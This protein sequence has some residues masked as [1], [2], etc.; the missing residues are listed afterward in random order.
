M[1]I[2]RI[3][4]GMSAA[5]MAASM[6]NVP[7]FADEGSFGT[8]SNSGSLVVSDQNGSTASD[9][10]TGSED[11]VYTF[12]WDQDF[13]EVP[14]DWYSDGYISNK[15]FDLIPKGHGAKFAVD[16]ELRL[17][18]DY[19]IMALSC[20]NGWS[21]LYDEL[22]SYRYDEAV[23]DGDEELAAALKP[24]LWKATS[25]SGIELKSSLSEEEIEKRIRTG[26]APVLQNDGFFVLYSSGTMEFEIS[27]DAVEYIRTNLTE[28][29]NFGGTLF[30]CYGVDITHIHVED[31]ADH[32]HNYEKKLIKDGHEEQYT[33]SICGDSYTKVIGHDYAETEMI[34]EP[35]CTEEGIVKYICS[36]GDSYTKAVSKKGHV[37]KEEKAA[38]DTITYV[39][40]NCDYVYTPAE[41]C[42]CD[43]ET[44]PN[45]DSEKDQCGCGCKDE[46]GFTAFEMWSDPQWSPSANWSSADTEDGHG[47]D[48]LINKDGTYTVSF[49]PTY[50]DATNDKVMYEKPSADSEPYVWKGGDNIWLVDI[51]GLADAVGANT[52]DVIN[53][54]GDKL[55][56]SEKHQL[57]KEAGIKITN[58]KLYVDGDL[59]YTIPDDKLLYGDLEENGN[60][61]IEIYNQFTQGTESRSSDYD[62]PELYNKLSGLTA[63]QVAVTFDIAGVPEAPYKRCVCHD[64]D[65]HTHVF[66]P[67]TYREPTCYRLGEQHYVC[68]ICGLGY[69]EYIETV[70]HTYKLADIITEPT[71]VRQ[72][73]GVYRCTVCGDEYMDKIDPVGH[74]YTT[75]VFEPSNTTRGYTEYTCENCGDTFKDDYVPAL[76]SHEYIGKITKMPTCTEEGV[77]TYTCDDGDDSYTEAIPALGH[78]YIDRV[79][80]ATCTEKGY[81]EHVCLT[82]GDK[83]TSD[84]TAAKGHSY[85]LKS[86]KAA[87][88][89][90][91]GSKTYVCES[92]GDSYV[93]ITPVRGHSYS[94]EV[95][96]PT[97][98]ERGYTLHTCS[99]CGDSYKDNFTARLERTSIHNAVISIANKKYVYS[100]KKIAPSFTVKLNGKLLVSG[101]DYSYTFKNNTNTGKA[102]LTIVGKGAYDET[103]SVNF[104]IKP[105]A[106]KLSKL[107]S[108]KSKQITAKWAKDSQATGYEMMIGTNK[109]MT[110]NKKTFDITKNS[111]VSKTVKGLKK[112]ATYYV[113]VRA[114]KT[115]N[116]EKYYGA[117]SSIKSV[118][119][120]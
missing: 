39:C 58:C 90:A 17:G 36:C 93:E 81:T 3:I 101:T 112:G 11:I 23:N 57:A 69:S 115:I 98:D 54:K 38:D 4:A 64:N 107:T 75:K 92:C 79:V 10:S 102:T 74:K 105:K 100:G 25:I 65:D 109:A 47:T 8:D 44:C 108:T 22:I 80:P 30:Q 110:K 40:E 12:P 52:N 97:Y 77:R 119:C 114:Y 55:N 89:T 28:E 73:E 106:V 67:G 82:C 2:K 61:R 84:E 85:R 6:L 113:K 33:C 78:S 26:G 24:S 96:A 48:A 70:P 42:G 103:K 62:I 19:S 68:D 71:C 16:Y 116:N 83:Y 72:G 117:Y 13:P 29:N 53:A 49:G 87:T 50:Y 56:Y 32:K 59:F 118:K 76:H 111:T 35:T 99:V 88:C 94:A 66:L 14:D 120:K 31:G 1:M 63:S 9:D 27:P 34:K 60:I 37:L 43:E 46:P 86:S 5:A 20:A 7:V 51:A 21:R 45:W 18:Y 91:T 15:M 95:V 41:G 104:F